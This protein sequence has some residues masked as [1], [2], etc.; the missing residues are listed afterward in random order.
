ME[1]NLIS[2]LILQNIKGVGGASLNKLYIQ[3]IFDDS[4]ISNI[5]GK[6]MEI[7]KKS[8][9]I[10][11]IGIAE[12]DAIKTLEYCLQKKINVVCLSS[13]EYPNALRGIK[14][15]PPVIYYK[16]DIGA[17]KKT[18]G[19]IGTRKPDENGA[20]IAKK[21]G[22]YFQENNFSITNGLEE[23]I[24][25]LSVLTEAGIYKN[26]I[27]V[28]GGGLDFETSKTITKGKQQKANLVIENEGLLISE[29]EPMVKEDSFKLINACRIQAGLS[30]G[31]IL[32]QSKLDG[33]SKYTLKAF[34]QL[35][36]PLGV[37]NVPDSI[38][39]LN[40]EANKTIIEQGTKGIELFTGL[41]SDKIKISHVLSISEKSN[42][43][44]FEKLINANNADDLDNLKFL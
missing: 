23:G 8:I 1:N 31:L 21:I 12:K 37:I 26:T 18:I 2:Y 22:N 20:K 38:Y 35:S 33:G 25:E 14:D 17:L 41:K 6:S 7:L 43:P 32:V 30:D 15:S 44:E 4:S 19:I 36:R 24:D 3:N 10:D 16:G 27:G 42:Y 39:N 28:L 9:S 5:V 13:K 40:F 29:F 34:A 11:E